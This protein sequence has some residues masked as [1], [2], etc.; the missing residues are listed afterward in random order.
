MKKILT[1]LLVGVACFALSSC[2]ANSSADE[3]VKKGDGSKW[4]GEHTGVIVCGE[5]PVLLIHSTLDCPAIVN[6]VLT[7]DD[8][9]KL[10]GG[11]NDTYWSTPFCTKCM[12]EE[13]IEKCKEWINKGKNK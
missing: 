8:V 10:Y 6:G 5:Y 4:W 13:L 9:Y 11:S 1:I 7:A 2:G 3:N 12:D